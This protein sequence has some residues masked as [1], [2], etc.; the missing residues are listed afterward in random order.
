[1]ANIYKIIVPANAYSIFELVYM[2][3]ELLHVSANHGAIFVFCIPTDAHMV[4]RNM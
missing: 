3:N 1:M 2:R 4:G